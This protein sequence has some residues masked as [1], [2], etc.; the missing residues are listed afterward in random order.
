MYQN[1]APYM[2]RYFI[3]HAWNIATRDELKKELQHAVV[4]DPLVENK[5]NISVNP[6]QDGARVSH[7]ELIGSVG[8]DRERKRVRQI[9]GVNTKD[10][11][12]IVDRLTVKE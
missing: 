5:A 11:V 2:S 6:I 12:D 4:E 8:S 7:I 1:A 3:T 9:I 10:E